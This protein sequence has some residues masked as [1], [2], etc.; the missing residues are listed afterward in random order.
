M[1]AIMVRLWFTALC[2]LPLRREKS[3]G[4]DPKPE[5]QPKRQPC[6][7]FVLTGPQQGLVGLRRVTGRVS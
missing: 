5:N 6:R 1:A 7:T 2:D 3:E 4:P